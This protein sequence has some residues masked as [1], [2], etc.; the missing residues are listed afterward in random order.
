M[1]NC[2]ETAPRRLLCIGASRKALAAGKRS[3]E[4]RRPQNERSP[5][6]ITAEA[7]EP[8]LGH[9]LTSVALRHFPFNV[10]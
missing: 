3:L 6:G 1:R 10:L 8:Y 7:G 5:R 2:E 9:T 4:S